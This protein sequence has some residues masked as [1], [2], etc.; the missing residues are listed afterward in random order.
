KLHG[1]LV[2]MRHGEA[3][4]GLA[5]ARLEVV[6]LLV[7]AHPRGLEREEPG[8]LEVRLHLHHVP[9]ASG[10]RVRMAAVPQ[11][12]P[13]LLALFFDEVERGAADADAPPRYGGPGGVE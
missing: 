2:D 9:L 8:G 5:D 10:E 6:V 7:V 11:L 13:S 12:H 3:R 4:L 1:V